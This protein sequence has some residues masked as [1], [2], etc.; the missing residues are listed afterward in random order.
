MRRYRRRDSEGIKIAP[1]PY[2][3]L[4]VAYLTWLGPL[5]AAKANDNTRA[6]TADAFCGELPSS[7]SLTPAKTRIC[8]A[9][10]NALLRNDHCSRGPGAPSATN[11]GDGG[12]PAGCGMPISWMPDRSSRIALG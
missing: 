6:T 3:Q 12:R 5:P 9:G 11:T 2:E 4:I 7:S 10:P 8:R 1:T